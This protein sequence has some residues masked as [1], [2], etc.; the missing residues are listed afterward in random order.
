MASTPHA[1]SLGFDLAIS[2]GIWLSLQQYVAS[3]RLR[4]AVTAVL[5]LG[6][7]VTYSRGPWAC[8]VLIYVAF[9]YLRPGSRSALFKSAVALVA[10]L[11]AI[12][13]SPFGQ[14]I[15]AL[16]PFLGGKVGDASIDY[17]K[18]LF[19]RGL[20][21]FRD[22]PLL[23]DQFALARMQDLRQGQGIIDLVNAYVSQGLATGAVGLAL[24]F[25][26]VLPALF[27]VMKASKSLIIVDKRFGS[28]GSSLAAGIIGTLFLWAFGGPDSEVLWA[29]VAMA[30]AYK[31][32]SQPQRVELPPESPPEI[33]A[34]SPED[35]QSLLPDCETLPLDQISTDVP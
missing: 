29:L 17:R 16:I 35:N 28:V 3:R 31:Y 12:S 4:H 19:D 26:I 2:F 18:R 34:E 24:F 13:L 32:M 10:V 7:I 11:G 27:K 20:E 25:F 14:K 5:C 8:A 1:L 23:G 21:I 15:T 9:V 30:I 6:L 33:R 22:H